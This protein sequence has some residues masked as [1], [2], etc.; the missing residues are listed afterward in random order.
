MLDHLY[1]LVT[2]CLIFQ[3]GNRILKGKLLWVVDCAS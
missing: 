1:V 2:Y 3:A